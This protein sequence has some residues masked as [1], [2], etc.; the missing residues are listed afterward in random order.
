[1]PGRYPAIEPSD[2]GWLDVGDGQRVYW[3]VCGEPAG[4]PAVVLHGGPGSGCGPW[5]RTYFDPAAY[6]IVLFDQRGCGRSLPDAG[7]PATDLA[8]NTTDHLVADIERLRRQLS[9][10]RWL[11]LGGSWGSTLALAYAQAH[12][13]RVTEMAL[14]AVGTDTRREVEWVTRD[15]G[16]FFPAAWARFRNGVPEAER[17]GSL[18]DAYSRLLESPDPEVRAKAARDWCDWEDAHVKTRPD[19]PADPRYE[20]PAFRARFARLVT[21]YWRHTAW[22]EEGEL[23]RGV[24]RLAGIPAVLIHGRLD[25]ELTARRRVASRSGLAGQRAG[26]PRRRGPHRRAGHNGRDRRGD[27]SLRRRLAQVGGD[28]VGEHAGPLRWHERLET[29]LGL[30]GP[31]D[32]IG[33]VAADLDDVVEP[34]G[35]R[36]ARREA[37]VRDRHET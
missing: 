35:D 30:A 16:R 7:D 3:E 20:D 6:R 8:A 31:H 5:W 1:M 24:E 2:H 13:N 15:A 32:Q 36:R 11:V 22:R 19:Q 17:E 34:D 25:V 4:K 26:D 10:E 12:R 28:A 33:T 29:A 27:G 18:V 23:L 9:I 14:F 21:H 37:L